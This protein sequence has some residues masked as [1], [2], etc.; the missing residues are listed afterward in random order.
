[1]VDLHATFLTSQDDDA[2]NHDNISDN[3]YSMA[4]T[5][6]IN[7]TDVVLACLLGDSAPSATVVNTRAEVERG[8]GQAQRS[9]YGRRYI[10]ENATNRARS[11]S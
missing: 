11:A 6:A 8:V 10:G 2:S 3:E 1:M 5:I 4:S 9:A 7:Q